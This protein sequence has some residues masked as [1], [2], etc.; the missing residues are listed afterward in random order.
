MSHRTKVRTASLS[1]RGIQVDKDEIEN[2]NHEAPVLGFRVEGYEIWCSQIISDIAFARNYVPGDIRASFSLT[3]DKR[4]K[5][6]K[7][8][9]KA[10]DLTDAQLAEMQASIMEEFQDRLEKLQT[11]EASRKGPSRIRYAEERNKGMGLTRSLGK[12]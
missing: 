6:V 8:C 4:G 9:T 2:P 5:T 7:L 1:P 3:Y 11:K 12:A 10:H